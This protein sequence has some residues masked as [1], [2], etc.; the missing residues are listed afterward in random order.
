M[1]TI[2]EQ[3]EDIQKALI[4]A[5]QL[6]LNSAYPQISLVFNNY[7]ELTVWAEN[8]IPFLHRLVEDYLKSQ[9]V[10]VL[11]EDQYFQVQN[12]IQTAKG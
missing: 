2:S 5:A 9:E 6:I 11:S 8:A 7:I 12:L 1:R 3:N 10:A 4:A